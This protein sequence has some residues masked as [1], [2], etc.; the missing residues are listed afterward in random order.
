M[1]FCCM[2]R[3]FIEDVFFC[4]FFLPWR[5]PVLCV[6]EQLLEGWRV[7]NNGTSKRELNF[8]WEIS[9]DFQEREKRLYVRD[10]NAEVGTLSDWRG[11]GEVFAK[12]STVSSSG[13][14]RSGNATAF[15]RPLGTIGM[16]NS[17]VRFGLYTW[18][19]HERISEYTYGYMWCYVARTHARS[20]TRQFQGLSA[21]AF[22]L[23]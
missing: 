11:G 19:V 14:R 10:L 5:G 7:I 6:L 4:S 8:I 18:H 21:I 9:S 23:I 17:H 3:T 12:K 13:V 15:V 16:C 20:H 1:G 2:S 22:N